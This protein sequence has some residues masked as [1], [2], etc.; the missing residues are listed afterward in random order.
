MHCVGELYQVLHE[1]DWL[2]PAIAGEATTSAHSSV[3]AS[4][5]LNDRLAIMRLSP[6]QVALVSH[7]M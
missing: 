2:V 6:F 4:P 3:A 7:Y 5:A 1:H